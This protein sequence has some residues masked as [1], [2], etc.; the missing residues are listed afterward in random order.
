MLLDEYIQLSNAGIDILNDVL[1]TLVLMM[2]MM[3][4]LFA[5]VNPSHGNGYWASHCIQINL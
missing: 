3:S 5:T 2:F 1:L 4:F